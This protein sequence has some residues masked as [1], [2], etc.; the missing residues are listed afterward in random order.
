MNITNLGNIEI[1]IP[2]D[3]EYIEMVRRDESAREK[4]N[5]VIEEAEIILDNLISN[6][7]TILF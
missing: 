7:N 6:D 4:I 2:K 5:E 3:A 1:S